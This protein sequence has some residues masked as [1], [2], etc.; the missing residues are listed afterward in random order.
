MYAST[1]LYIYVECICAC[2]HAYI[3]TCT[4]IWFKVTCPCAISEGTPSASL[5]SFLISSVV[6]EREV[7]PF[8]CSA[9]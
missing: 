1:D 5:M 6:E 3:V 2:V 9:V 8:K 4:S 7:M